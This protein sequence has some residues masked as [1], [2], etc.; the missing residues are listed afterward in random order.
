MICRRCER[1]DTPND[2]V[3]YCLACIKEFNKREKEAEGKAFID[4]WLKDSKF[5]DR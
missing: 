1:N 3:F 4:K 2:K 5:A